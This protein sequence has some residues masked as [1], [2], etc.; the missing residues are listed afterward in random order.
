MKNKMPAGT[1]TYLESLVQKMLEDHG[2]QFIEKNK[3]M[4]ATNILEQKLYTKQLSSSDSMHSIGDSKDGV[5][6][7]FTIYNPILK[8]KYIIQI[9]KFTKGETI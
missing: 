3:F 2:Y 7:E 6:G 8:E 9:T 1:G 4:V 5:R